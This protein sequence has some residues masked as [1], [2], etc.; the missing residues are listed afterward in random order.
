VACEDVRGT[1]GVFC[2]IANAAN[3]NDNNAI[4]TYNA[5]NLLF[6]LLLLNTRNCFVIRARTY[7]AN[8]LPEVPGNGDGGTSLD[9]EHHVP[10]SLDAVIEQRRA[11][12]RNRGA[13]VSEAR[14]MGS[15][16]FRRCDSCG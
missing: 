2:E 13:V 1:E 15:K 9:Q 3:E 10:Y 11:S 12:V 8:L 16:V 4:K 6:I 5:R 7:P 14:K